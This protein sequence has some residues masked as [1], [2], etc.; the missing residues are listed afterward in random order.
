MILGGN[1]KITIET[2]P[3]F[4]PAWIIYDG[5]CIYS[6]LIIIR[7]PLK[8]SQQKEQ[9]YYELIDVRQNLSLLKLVIILQLWHSL[10]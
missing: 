4:S 1:G 8:I 6:V 9:K 5:K 7:L 10:K 2:H 3:F